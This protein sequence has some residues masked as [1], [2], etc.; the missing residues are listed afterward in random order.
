MLPWLFPLWMLAAVVAVSISNVIAFALAFVSGYI[1][2][3]SAVAYIR[4]HTRMPDGSTL[5][6]DDTDYWQIK[7]WMQRR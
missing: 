5:R 7:H 6:D 4:S 1:A 3:P 2:F